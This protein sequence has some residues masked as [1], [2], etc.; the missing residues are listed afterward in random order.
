MPAS[1]T[2]C[3]NLGNWIVAFYAVYVLAAVAV[4]AAA[5]VMIDW[6]VNR[7]RASR[8]AVA[9]K[10]SRAARVVESQA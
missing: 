3:I 5:A 6:T 4:I 2:I 7:V 8:V 10:V 9:A 1:E